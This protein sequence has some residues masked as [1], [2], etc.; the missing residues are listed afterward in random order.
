MRVLIFHGY[1]LRGTGSNVYNA[2]L[3]QALARL[4]H[5]VHLLCQDRR[6]DELP[7][8]GGEGRPGTVSV[9]VP[10]IGGLLPV[11]VADRY[12]GFEVK[13]FPD[14][15]D[16]ELE[17]YLESNVAAV[18]D[19]IARVG[20][21]DAAL[22]NHLIMG[23][24]ILARAGLE[25]AIK[26]HGSDLSYTVRP[27]PDRFVPFAREG[28]DAATGLLVGSRY[29][30]EDLWKTVDDPGLPD[31]TRLG[32]PGVNTQE[33][34]PSP[35]AE[36]LPK[37]VELADRI[38]D[39]PPDESF[40][41][42]GPA[43]ASALR[44]WVQ[45]SPR[46]LFVGK[47]LT[48]KGVDLL[49][50]AWP[51]V[52]RLHP[53]ATLLLAGFGDLRSALESRIGRARGLGGGLDLDQRPARARRGRRGDARRPHPRDAERLSRRRSA[54]SPRRP[55]PAGCRR[56]R[57]TTRGCGR[58]RARWPRWSPST[59]GCS[60]SRSGDD[61]PEAIAER[62]NGW[63]ALSEAERERVGEALAARVHEL[64]SWERVAEGVIAA[65]RGELDALP[66][67]ASD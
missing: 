14:L 8:V 63:L 11:Y 3:A 5:E 55:R 36:A 15:S 25:F 7:W 28:T 2:N 23:P 53:E 43:A 66:R 49:V 9:T 32:P 64:W 40:G 27:H 19:L 10:D 1:L 58:S 39:E 33:F 57:P 52:R 18:R 29:T 13:T 61:A 30:A 20:E 62:I 54:W 48:N 22:A 42:D 67:V 24:V 12:E 31:R 51:A 44:A 38:S 45:G 65:S 6:A 37:V 16:E 60:R 17:R 41:R 4:G 21:P 59:P 50:A 46:V 26:V 35:E 56:S 34:R 47:L